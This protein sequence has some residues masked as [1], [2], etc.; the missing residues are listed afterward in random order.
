M[1]PCP[2]IAKSSAETRGDLIV[3]LFGP[4]I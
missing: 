1:L 4:R 2:V 3:S